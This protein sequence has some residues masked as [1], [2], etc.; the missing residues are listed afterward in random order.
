MAPSNVNDSV[1]GVSSERDIQ[2]V[3][4]LKTAKR[5]GKEVFA[6][7][8]DSTASD[9]ELSREDVLTA[10]SVEE[11]RKLLRKVDWRLIP[12]LCLLYL[13]KKLDE[14][15]VGVFRSR[16]WLEMSDVF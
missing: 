7:N 2:S 3:A 11:E 1:L 12:L 5:A 13:V 10:L 14:N 8:D 16:C 15:N 6:S 4:D 9:V